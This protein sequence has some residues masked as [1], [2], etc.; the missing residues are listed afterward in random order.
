MNCSYSQSYKATTQTF[1]WQE[2]QAWT[3]DYIFFL[4]RTWNKA[5]F[6]R[7]NQEQPFKGKFKL[8][9]YALTSFIEMLIL[10]NQ[11]LVL[12]LLCTTWT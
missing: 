5:L 8:F 6:N 12:D 11:V 7:L 4:T 2:I 3:E 1:P 9:M 10:I